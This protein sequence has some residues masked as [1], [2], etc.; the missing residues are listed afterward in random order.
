MILA[1]SIVTLTVVQT[2]N[3]NVGKR[4]RSQSQYDTRCYG[5][6]EQLIDLRP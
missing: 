4:Y 2:S 6:R 3:C 1:G 5:G